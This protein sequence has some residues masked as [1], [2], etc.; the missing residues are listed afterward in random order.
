MDGWP[1][2]HQIRPLRLQA[3]RNKR[4][5]WREEDYVE[6][7]DEP[8]WE[9]EASQRQSLQLPENGCPSEAE[10]AQVTIG[11]QTWHQHPE[12]AVRSIATGPGA[13]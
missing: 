3:Q 13:L 5:S 10:A 11:C 2:S 7:D 4:D 1:G 12:L 6:L 8:D 9:E